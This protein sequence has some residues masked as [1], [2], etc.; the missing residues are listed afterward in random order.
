MT[1]IYLCLHVQQLVE[2]AA[3]MLIVHVQEA[4]QQAPLPVPP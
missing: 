2:L 3:P 1:H 4:L